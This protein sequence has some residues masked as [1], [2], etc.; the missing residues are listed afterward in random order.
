[1]CCELTNSNHKNNH[2]ITLTV[3]S[4]YS[5]KESLWIAIFSCALLPTIHRI[6]SEAIAEHG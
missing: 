5:Y 3:I 6:R 4:R 2:T 1:M